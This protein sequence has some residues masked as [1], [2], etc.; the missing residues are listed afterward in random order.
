MEFR[1]KHL[2]KG[3][4]NRPG[5]AM[6]PLG[7][8]FHTTNNWSDGAGDEAH[9]EYM[10]NT[11]RVVSWHETVDKDSCTQHIPH[12]E[13]AWHAGDGGGHYNRNWLGL[14]IACEA[15]KPGEKLDAATYKNAVLRAA[16]ICKQYGYGWGQLQPHYVVWGKNCPH[17]TLFSRDQFKKDVFAKVAELSKKAPEVPKKPE[18]DG[19]LHV[20]KAGDTLTEIAEMYNTSVIKLSQLNGITDPNRIYVGQRI[21]LQGSVAA[22]IKPKA[23]V[24]NATPVFVLPPA[25][26]SM[27]ASGEKVIDLQQALTKLK[28]NPGTIDGRFGPKTRDAVAR[29]Q[30]TLW[31]LRNEKR[32]VYT[33]ATR[34]EMARKL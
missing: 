9:A 20:V 29:F 17:T 28:F 21:K 24:K 23:P 2:P 26:I 5:H 27:N 32:G 18:G 34:L 31:A 1:I 25:P 10:N 19:F 7:L 33:A 12:T 3:H 6:K 22:V 14:E 11:T 30:S 8:L 4:R 13:N 16:Q 15:V